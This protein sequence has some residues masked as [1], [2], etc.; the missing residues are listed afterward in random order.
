MDFQ[1]ALKSPGCLQGM[2]QRWDPPTWQQVPRKTCAA[3]RGLPCLAQLSLEGMDAIAHGLK[4]AQ[5]RRSQATADQ[6][7]SQWLN[8]SLQAR[9]L[10]GQHGEAWTA[11][12]QGLVRLKRACRCGT[13]PTMQT[14]CA[15]LEG[16]GPIGLP[17]YHTS[18]RA[19]LRLQ[20][21]KA[22]IEL[23]CPF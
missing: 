19:L 6:G 23:R 12:K 10:T 4:A 15:N 3:A 13:T 16:V 9:R 8:I 18:L 14:T 11:C 1:A 21:D 17:T 2:R 5:S 7:T 22:I 20:V